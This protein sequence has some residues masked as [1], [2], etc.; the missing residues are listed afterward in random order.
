MTKQ[1]QNVSSRSVNGTQITYCC[2]YWL[3]KKNSNI[4]T[5]QVTMSTKFA[6]IIG[7]RK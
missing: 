7:F 3:P 1:L 6:Y 4:Q 5:L 2:F